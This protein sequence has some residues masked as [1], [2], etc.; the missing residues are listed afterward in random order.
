MQGHIA[1]LTVLLAP[2]AAFA[3]GDSAYWDA[4][5]GNFNLVATNNQYAGKVY[6]AS[7]ATQTD[8]WIA[9]N[10]GNAG[11]NSL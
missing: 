8:C 2:F 7:T 3:Q 5:D 6:K 9:L 4:T 11:A 1:R 10:L